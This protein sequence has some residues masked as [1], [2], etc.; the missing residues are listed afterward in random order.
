MSF[1]D[2]KESSSIHDGEDDGEEYSHGCDE[3][4]RI[5]DLEE[6]EEGDGTCYQYCAYIRAYQLRLRLPGNMEIRE[7]SGNHRKPC[8]DCRKNDWFIGLFLYIAHT[9]IL[10][11]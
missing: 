8:S 5:M 11:S 6:A 10:L 4:G 7:V 1:S 3:C 2:S 9:T